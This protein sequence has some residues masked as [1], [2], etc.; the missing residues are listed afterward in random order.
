MREI[1]SKLTIKTPERPAD[2]EIV[3][4]GLVLSFLL[5]FNRYF[6]YTIVRKT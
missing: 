4:T 5:T 2:F 6:P 1:C 3:N